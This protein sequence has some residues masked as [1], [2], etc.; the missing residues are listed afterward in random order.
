MQAQVIH[1]HFCVKFLDFTVE[2]VACV[3]QLLVCTA[4]TLGKLF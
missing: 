3:T 4:L 2:H 1:V